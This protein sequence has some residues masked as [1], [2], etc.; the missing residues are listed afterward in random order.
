[1]HIDRNEIV[2]RNYLEV[3]EALDTKKIVIEIVDFMPIRYLIL[4]LTMRC[5]LQCSY[6]YY[7]ESCSAPDMTAKVMQQAMSLVVAGEQRFHLQLTGGEATLVPELIERAAIL[8][9]DTGRCGSMGVQTNTTCLSSDL[10]DIL[11]AHSFQV[12]VS[13]DGPPPIQHLQ[14]GMASETFQGLQ[15]LEA[16]GIPFNVTTVVTQA[17]AAFLDSL[18][19]AVA[20]FACVRGIGLDLLIN[21][22][23]AKDS[24]FVAPA[25]KHIL[26]NGLQKMVAA[27]DGVNERRSVPI[28]LRERDLL[29][30]AKNQKC[31]VFC[32]ACLG[33]S[34]AVQPDGKI[35]PC[36][37]T[38]GDSR[39]FAGT[40]WEPRFENLKTLSNF[41]PHGALCNS[42]DLEKICPGDCPSRLF[43]NQQEN[44][45]QVCDLYHALWQ[46][47]KG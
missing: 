24:A 37:Q 30:T 12:G 27:L 39:F 14:R 7:G 23:R 9:S 21:K 5:N 29:L 10:L 22:G 4:V 26:T 11:K 40:V 16:A 15:R 47:E 45:T 42:C 33:E 34:I 17:N 31:S 32:H 43:Y 25:D 19:L 1:M 8:A 3:G 2:K 46:I 13:L 18:V 36:G 20:G 41:K 44:P 6:C 38:L 35:F 28:R